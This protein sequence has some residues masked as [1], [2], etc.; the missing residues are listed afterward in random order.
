MT[1]KQYDVRFP[2]N[3]FIK[4]IRLDSDFIGLYAITQSAPLGAQI[5]RNCFSGG[6]DVSNC[7][8]AIR[9][10]RSLNADFH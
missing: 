7:F 10:Q 1:V 2:V 4:A 5:V 8:H 6:N 9:K 3:T